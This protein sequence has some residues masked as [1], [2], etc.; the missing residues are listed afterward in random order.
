MSIST[1]AH[2]NSSVITVANSVTT[3][4]SNTPIVQSIYSSPEESSMQANA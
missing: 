1:V 3:L 2:H 4:S